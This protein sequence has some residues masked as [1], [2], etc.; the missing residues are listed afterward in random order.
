MTRISR[1]TQIALRVCGF[2]CTRPVETA[3]SEGSHESSPTPTGHVHDALPNA[4]RL[5][6]RRSAALTISSGSV[7]AL[8]LCRLRTRSTRGHDISWSGLLQQSV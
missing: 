6:A 5:L 8:V 4:E 7:F 3:L 1:G 2:T